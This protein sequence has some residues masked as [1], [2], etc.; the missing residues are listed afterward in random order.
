MRGK[1]FK[2]TRPDFGAPRSPDLVDRQFIA[3]RPNE[4]WVADFTYVATW[5]GF[6]FDAFMID[7]YSRM[8]VGWCVSSSVK[9]E[10]VLDALEQA[11]YARRETDGLVD[12]SNRGAATCRSGTAK[13]SGEA[14]AVQYRISHGA[15][16]QSG[17]GACGRNDFQERRTRSPAP[18]PRTVRKRYAK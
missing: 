14:A 13:V 16:G 17:A 11:L 7:V 12:H 10:L 1:A 6:V 18:S 9:T 4:L 5:Q 3:T 15:T 8:I 2:T